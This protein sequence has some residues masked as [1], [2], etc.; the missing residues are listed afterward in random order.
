MIYSGKFMLIYLLA[1]VLLITSFCCVA[2]CCGI[3]GVIRA[4]RSKEEEGG[5]IELFE[6]AKD[7]NKT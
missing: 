6:S 7:D 4:S 1:E 3:C 5:E 2:C